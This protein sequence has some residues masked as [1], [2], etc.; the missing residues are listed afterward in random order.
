MNQLTLTFLNYFFFRPIVTLPSKEYSIAAKFCPLLFC[1]RH[2]TPVIPLPYRMIIAVA[3]RSSVIL[4]DTEQST[5]FAVISNIHY[6]RL[7]DISWSSDGKI[8][9]VSSTD[10]F[11]S[12]ITF[13]SDELG[14]IYKVEKN[15]ENNNKETEK[16]AK[17]N[18]HVLDESAMDCTEGTEALNDESQDEI[19]LVIEDSQ[20]DG[21]DIVP[22]TQQQ[23]QICADIESEKD[24][25]NDPT[26]KTDIKDD[27][28][29]TAPL[30][31]DSVT[32]D[33]KPVT[34]KTP[35]RV[36][37]ITLSSPKSSKIK[38]KE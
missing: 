26:Q 20:I 18:L 10:G 17:I 36:S 25:H 32:K 21:E 15:S 29:E 2:K 1:L 33:D 3:T 13:S 9:A 22:S 6:T 31:K 23:K 11:C 12:I 37:L 16:S 35:R 4:Y 5:P 27:I 34:V 38:T 24:S 30:K 7:T 19:R 28:K 8:L 14:E